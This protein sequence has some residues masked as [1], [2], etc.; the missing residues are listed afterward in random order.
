[1]VPNLIASAGNTVAS[2][3]AALTRNSAYLTEQGENVTS[4]SQVFALEVL[5]AAGGVA[6]PVLAANTDLN[7]PAPGRP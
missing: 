2:V 6:G 4:L 7:V 5:N 1:M 3:Q